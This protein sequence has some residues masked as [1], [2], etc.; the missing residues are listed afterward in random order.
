[1]FLL[2]VFC[3]GKIGRGFHAVAVAFQGYYKD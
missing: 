1:M 2:S 3:G